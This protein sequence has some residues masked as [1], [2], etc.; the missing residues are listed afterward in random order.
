MTE[1]GGNTNDCGCPIGNCT[2]PVQ[3]RQTPPGGH[4]H[5]FHKSE[6]ARLRCYAC[7]D[8]AKLVPS[9]EDLALVRQ[10][11]VEGYLSTSNKYRVVCKL[12]VPEFDQLFVF[13][14]DDVPKWLRAELRDWYTRE[15]GYWTRMHSDRH[16]E[17]RTL[18]AAQFHAFKQLGGRS[19]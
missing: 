4:P 8:P 19:A 3:P 1:H 18:T 2:C 7:S 5:G 9:E 13:D 6:A 12:N 10:L 16:G 14:G 17:R 11:I 15:R